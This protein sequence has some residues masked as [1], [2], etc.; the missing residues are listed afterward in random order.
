MTN[1]LFAKPDLFKARR[2][3][4][5]QPHYDDNDIAAGGILANLTQQGAEI[6]LTVTDD[7]AGVV[8]Q[9]LS[10]IKIGSLFKSGSGTGWRPGW[11]AG[12]ILVGI[13]GR[14]QI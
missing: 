6:F 2:I 9:S 7:L 8:D 1:E 14:R 11:R 5:V 12:S 3:L 10:D 13:S 4:A